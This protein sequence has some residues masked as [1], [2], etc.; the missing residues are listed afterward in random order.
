MNIDLE[1]ALH[2]LMHLGDIHVGHLEGSV[3]SSFF[4]TRLALLRRLQLLPSPICRMA[5]RPGTPELVNV[6]TGYA[7]LKNKITFESLNDAYSEV[8]RIFPKDE[9]IKQSIGDIKLYDASF[10]ELG[11]SPSEREK[12]LSK[13]IS[14]MTTLYS[15]NNSLDPEDEIYLD[16][17]I[18][19]INKKI[20]LNSFASM[21]GGR[22]KRKTRRA[23]R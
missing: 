3:D 22:R 2:R 9:N 15:Y 7:T 8:E 4:S 19:Y 10:R 11:V 13:F 14:A 6:E 1:N 12:R 21:F 18:E 20:W 23:R 5:Q 17:A 16:S